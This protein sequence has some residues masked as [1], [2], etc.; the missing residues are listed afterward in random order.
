MHGPIDVTHRFPA[1]G[2]NDASHQPDFQHSSLP[3]TLV[4]VSSAATCQ[5][6]PPSLCASYNHHLGDLHINWRKTEETLRSD[7]VDGDVLVLLDTVYK[8]KPQGAKV[9]SVSNKRNREIT[10]HCELMSA[11]ALE[12]TTAPPGA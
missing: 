8:M 4:M 9:E 1:D 5:F 7:E 11:Y 2:A 6:K 10:R 3:F 12:S